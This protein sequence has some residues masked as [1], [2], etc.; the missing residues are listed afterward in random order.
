MYSNRDTQLIYESYVSLNESRNQYSLPFTGLAKFSDFYV[1]ELVVAKMTNQHI[2][3]H[4]KDK[5]VRLRDEVM[6]QLAD[7]M[8]IYLKTAVLLEAAHIMIPDVFLKFE[9]PYTDVDD[10]E[11][12]MDTWTHGAAGE[13]LDVLEKFM[14]HGIDQ[15]SEN[16]ID[17]IMKLSST[18]K[19]DGEDGGPIDVN[20]E[21]AKINPED[22]KMIFTRLPWTSL[23]GGK[24]WAD[25]TDTASELSKII[26]SG[27]GG[28][29]LIQYIDHIYDLQHNSGTLLNKSPSINVPKVILDLRAESSSGELAQRL[30]PTA[31]VRDI[32]LRMRHVLT[33]HERVPDK[34]DNYDQNLIRFFTSWLESTLW[35]N[36][37]IRY[38]DIAQRYELA[39]TKD[40][41]NDKMKSF[42]NNWKLGPQA[43][44]NA[45]EFLG[46]I[47]SSN[48][49]REILGIPDGIS[50][51]NQADRAVLYKKYLVGKFK[52][53]HITD[54]GTSLF[55]PLE[56]FK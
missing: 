46:Y 21:W 7:F 15:D 24:A 42:S 25:A 16:T 2:S 20:A 43:I 35:F 33:K 50:V 23:Y 53:I 10:L 13:I 36:L 49:N 34:D 22:L 54:D 39:F 45:N 32:A 8:A 40:Q 47:N 11:Q 1:I 48:R 4:V 31:A 14:F 12:M 29:K 30:K 28:Y 52:E 56:I 19:L 18:Y 6:F 17:D 38:S 5:I 3:E 41:V 44:E 37:K 51:F 55:V 26:K 9:N 27:K